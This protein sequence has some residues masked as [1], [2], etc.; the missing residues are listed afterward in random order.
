MALRKGELVM[1]ERD[2]R[3]EL[4]V[5]VQVFGAL[6]DAADAATCG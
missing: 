6:G 3:E 2:T 1:A 4:Q 5:R